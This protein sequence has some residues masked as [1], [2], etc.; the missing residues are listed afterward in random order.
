MF[1]ETKDEILDNN[2]WPQTETNPWHQTETNPWGGAQAVQ[3]GKTVYKIALIGAAGV[4]KSSIMRR[5]GGQPFDPRY[6]PTVGERD[7]VLEMSDVCL[8]IKEYAGQERF[9]T[10][11]DMDIDGI[12]VVTTASTVD[13]RIA[14][15]IMRQMPDVPY[16]FVENKCDLRVNHDNLSCSA[17]TQHNLM[18]SFEALVNKMIEND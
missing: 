17:K 15:E 2:A 1:E 18:E 8:H 10:V 14:F 11:Y 7:Y 4:G 5:L 9:Q 12:L 6:T 13:T 16:C 3:T